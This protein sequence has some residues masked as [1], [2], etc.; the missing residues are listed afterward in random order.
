[1]KGKCPFGKIKCQECVMYRKGMRYFDAPD[2]NGK[3]RPPEPFEE[4]AI[5]IG[6]D[7]LENM[8]SRMIG[9]QKAMEEV[10]NEVR[11]LTNLLI[12]AAQR[13]ALAE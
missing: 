8:V 10:R 4:C 5:V 11:N 2:A 7:C 3:A 1:M 13:K 6:V 12:L 9:G